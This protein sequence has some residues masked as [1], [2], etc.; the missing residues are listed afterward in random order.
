[1]VMVN[2]H[3]MCLSQGPVLG[4][5][6]C[7]PFPLITGT[8]FQHLWVKAGS[9][10]ITAYF[11]KIFP[12]LSM[13][14]SRNSHGYSNTKTFMREMEIVITVPMTQPKVRS[15]MGSDDSKAWDHWCVS[16]WFCRTLLWSF[17]PIFF[18]NFPGHFRI[19]RRNSCKLFRIKLCHVFKYYLPCRSHPVVIRYSWARY[20]SLA[21]LDI[22]TTGLYWAAGRNVAQVNLLAASRSFSC[23]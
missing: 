19:C 15:V 23:S 12:P 11:V 20:A 5:I 21:G 1:M 22:V 3:T 6:G 2:S 16:I 4:G 8:V 13:H 18:W 17:L 10:R 7:P 9:R 14:K